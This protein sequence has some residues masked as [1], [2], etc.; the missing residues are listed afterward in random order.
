MALSGSLDLDRGSQVKQM[1]SLCVS[2]E[3][4]CSCVWGILFKH[5]TP[6]FGQAAPGSSAMLKT[7]GDSV[8]VRTGYLTPS[9]RALSLYS[10][11][12]GSDPDRGIS[13]MLHV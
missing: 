13:E 10:L 12:D 6:H 4:E 3:T 11:C 1:N 5:A 8:F 7:D 9:T 2:F